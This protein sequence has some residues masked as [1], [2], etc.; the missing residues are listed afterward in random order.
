LAALL[1]VLA[2]LLGACEQKKSGPAP[3]G[4]VFV[5]PLSLNIREEIQPGS[6]TVAALKHGERLE[7][8]QT[9]RRFVRV[10]TT[11][12]QEGWTEMR[13]LLSTDQMAALREFSK[14]A[15]SLPAQG[16]A[17]VYDLLNM[18]S[19]PAR[20]SPSMYQI[21]EGM[22][23]DVLAHILT[24]RNSGTSAP[25]IS[26]EKPKPI[27]KTK[28]QRERE[29]MDKKFPPPPMPE[30]PTPPRNWVEMSKSVIPAEETEMDIVDPKTGKKRKR[31]RRQPGPSQPSD[32]W[33]LVR[34]ADGKAG[35]VLTRMLRM[36]IP[37][38]V[39]QYSEGARITSYFPLV[40]VQ[41][42]EQ[43]PKHHWLWTTI[44]DGGRPFQFDS[45][46]VFIWNLK[47]HRYETSYIQRDLVGYYPIEV[48]PGTNPSFS[49]IFQSDTDDQLYRYTF[50]ME[51]YITR[52]VDKQPAAKPSQPRLLALTTRA[53]SDDEDKPSPS[54]IERLKSLV[55]RDNATP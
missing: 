42:S 46:R 49:L 16:Q 39:A 14:R 47:K 8:L 9:R 20:Q 2:L 45:F 33:T 41:D 4:T 10:R 34:T 35:W 3:I 48:K 29:E 31:K 55:K 27:R 23:V 1:V 19:E 37:D 25:Q 5:A 7:V 51:G 36:S 26:F 53:S 30:P 38:E 28:K 21:K 22:T 24:P 15:A 44:R 43:G 50:K 52:L 12:G 11:G 54:I 32:D 17:T 13:N 6:K 18:H 40:E